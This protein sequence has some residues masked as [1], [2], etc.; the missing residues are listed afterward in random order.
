MHTHL[1]INLYTWEAM[2]MTTDWRASAGKSATAG[3]SRSHTHASLP[4]KTVRMG[5]VYIDK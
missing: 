2:A 1:C 3:H 4:Y 5:Y